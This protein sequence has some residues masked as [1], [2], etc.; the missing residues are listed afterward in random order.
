MVHETKNI[1]TLEPIQYTAKS[2]TH[3]VS[4]PVSSQRC[5]LDGFVLEVNRQLGQWNVLLYKVTAKRL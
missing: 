1:E 3:P 2:L 4:F 5:G